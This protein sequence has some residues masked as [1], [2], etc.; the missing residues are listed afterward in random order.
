MKAPIRN[1]SL[2][3]ALM[4]ASAFMAWS[5]VPADKIARLHPFVLENEIP[6]AFGDWVVDD[7]AVSGVVNPEQAELL[8]HLYSQMLSRSYLNRRSGERI[9]LS[10]AYGEDQRDSS[11]VHYPEIC[12]PAQGFS[13]VSN[14]EGKLL[15]GGG[16]LPVRRLETVFQDSRYEPVTYWIMTGDAASIGG[17]RKK[18]IELKYGLRGKIPDG[19]VFRVSSI[20]RDSRRAFEFQQLFVA[21]LLGAV[22]SE[23]RRRI[24][25]F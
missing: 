19:L 14:A 17:V 22:P 23:A 15:V 3:A 9:M 5:A 8:K 25:G 13:V 21:D 4:F 20:D 7:R 10:I 6:K 12:Y 18:L 24:A 1:A 16:E 2:A 11:Q